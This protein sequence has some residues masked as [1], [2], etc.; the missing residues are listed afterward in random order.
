MLVVEDFLQLVRAAGIE[1]DIAFV[2]WI[3]KIL[4]RLT[5]FD[6]CCIVFLC[7]TL[8]QNA[9]K[10]RQKD[11]ALHLGSGAVSD[12]FHLIF[13]FDGCLHIQGHACELHLNDVDQRRL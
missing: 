13:D 10:A 2:F 7:C 5:F 8:P 4:P 9:V 3:R 1:L 12:G 6:V 11:Q